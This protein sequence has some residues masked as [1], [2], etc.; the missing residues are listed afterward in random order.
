MFALSF[1]GI[2]HSEMAWPNK[3]SLV[4][5]KYEVKQPACPG[6]DWRWHSSIQDTEEYNT[7][8]MA[9]NLGMGPKAYTTATAPI[10]DLQGMAQE[11]VS[12]TTHTSVRQLCW[13]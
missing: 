2:M 12:K 6:D 1:L 5:D 9:W 11:H 10:K 3:G 7:E 4:D 8:P 13:S